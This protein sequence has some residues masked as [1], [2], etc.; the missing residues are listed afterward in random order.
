M[1]LTC[2]V[3]KIQRFFYCG[4]AATNELHARTL[5][6]GFLGQWQAN[7][8]LFPRGIDMILTGI[9]AASGKPVIACLPRTVRISGTGG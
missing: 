3:G 5:P 4:I 8:A 9:D 6:K 1:Y 7:G 2:D